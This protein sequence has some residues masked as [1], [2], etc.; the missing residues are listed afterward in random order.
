MRNA[1]YQ[2]IYFSSS[3]PAHG[4]H[5]PHTPLR[6]TQS[7]GGQDIPL[8]ESVYNLYTKDREK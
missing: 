1:I 4:P 7:L 3:T 5:K 2:F 8:I 6:V